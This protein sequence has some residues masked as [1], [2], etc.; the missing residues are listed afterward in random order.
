M[1]LG[2][3]LGAMASLD[4]GVSVSAGALANG[5][6]KDLGSG[7]RKPAR[8]RARFASSQSG[9]TDKQS[10]DVGVQF[11]EDGTN[12]SDD[13]DRD[14]VFTWDANALG[15]SAGADLTRSVTVCFV[16]KARYYRFRVKNYNG[17][18]AISFSSEVAEDYVT[19]T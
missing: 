7:T 10:I 2:L 11:S 18:D 19:D 3:K 16:P 13:S 17:T 1:D 12:W 9:G 14:I 15:L 5:T 6:A 4:S 8:C